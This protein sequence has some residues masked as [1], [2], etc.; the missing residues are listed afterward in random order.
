LI[1]EGASPVRIPV[2][3]LRQAYSPVRSEYREGVQVD[4]VQWAFVKRNPSVETLS[5]FGVL[6]L[7]AP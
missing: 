5:I 2:P 7:V 1:I 6:T 3:V 4:D